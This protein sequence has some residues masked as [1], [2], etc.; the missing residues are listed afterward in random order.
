MRDEIIEMAAKAIMMDD[1]APDLNQLLINNAGMRM[2]I[3][4]FGFWGKDFGDNLKYYET[5]RELA[6]KLKELIEPDYRSTYIEGK[7]RPE[8]KGTETL[9]DVV[10]RVEDPR[11]L[12]EKMQAEGWQFP[13]VSGG[14]PSKERRKELVAE[15]KR[16]INRLIAPRELGTFDIKFTSIETVTVEGQQRS[17]ELPL[18]VPG[19]PPED[20]FDATWLQGINDA[21]RVRAWCAE[22]LEG[23]EGLNA[24]LL[25]VAKVCSDAQHGWSL[26]AGKETRARDLARNLG[27]FVLLLEQVSHLTELETD[28]TKAP[29]AHLSRPKDLLKMVVEQRDIARGMIS[30]AAASPIAVFM[31][32]RYS[33]RSV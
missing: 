28:A 24:Q 33:N 27:K 25:N 18:R 17:E 30:D 32:L 31:W 11:F 10:R 8:F 13:K 3:A 16:E 19:F 2:V 1:L 23:P 15:W 21:H 14:Q 22:L 29:D 26:A 5:L 4:R 7:L 6:L 12:L 9:A 20:T